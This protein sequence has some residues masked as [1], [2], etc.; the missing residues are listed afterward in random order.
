MELEYTDTRRRGKVIIAIGL[1]LA[2]AAG[3]AAFFLINQAQQQAGQGSLQRV[4]IVVAKRQIAARKAI[5]A[6]DVER[7]DVPI[8][9]TNAQGVFSKESEVIGLV[10]GV[11]IL[12]GQPVYANLLASN[13][14][15][16]QF[17]ILEPGA[18]VA[19]DSP[20]WRAVSVTVPDDRAIGGQVQPGDTVDV[21]VT[22]P[23][24][25]STDL[26]AAG[27]YT[28]DKSTKITYQN[29]IVLSKATTFYILR[30]PLAMAEEINHL[31][32]TGTAAF[33]FALRPRQDARI[34]DV[35]SLG[36]T[37]N[38]IVKRYGLPIPEVYPRG[39]GPLPTPK[40]SASP[41]PSSSGITP[42]R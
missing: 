7:R 16:G 5:D 8:D 41:S 18:T 12:A 19:P 32:A 31:Q 6:E 13:V 39:N 27:R 34:L 1:I 10:A 24:T 40:P 21:F 42:L 30:V 14:Q 20:A 25:I 3:G 37:T 33:S 22:A 2:I 28:T 9:P 35:S 15:G 26:A 4:S 23:I 11:T 29:L 38:L 17:S 36:E